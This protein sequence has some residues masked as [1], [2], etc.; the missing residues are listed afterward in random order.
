VKQVGSTYTS[1]RCAEYGFTADEN[2]LTRNDFRCVKCES[3]ANA[4]YNAV[5]GLRPAGSKVA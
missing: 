3:A 1:K 4:D 5:A 2:R